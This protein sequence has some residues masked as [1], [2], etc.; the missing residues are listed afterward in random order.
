MKVFTSVIGK[1]C[2]TPGHENRFY[3]MLIAVYPLDLQS[4]PSQNIASWRM[5]QYHKGEQCLLFHSLTL[6]IV[7]NRLSRSFLQMAGE[8]DMNSSLLGKSGITSSRRASG[9]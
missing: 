9:I 7:G 2:S 5:N 6:N 4:L 3:P 8:I 1:A